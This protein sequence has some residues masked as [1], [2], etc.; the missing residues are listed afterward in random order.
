MGVEV[1]TGGVMGVTV[2]FAV[3]ETPTVVVAEDEQI[4][5]VL[6]GTLSLPASQRKLPDVLGQENTAT[7]PSNLK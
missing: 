1:K 3:G 2:G 5:Q 6:P 4:L 7:V